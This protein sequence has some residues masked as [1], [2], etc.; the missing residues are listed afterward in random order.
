MVNKIDKHMRMNYGNVLP[1]KKKMWECQ[2]VLKELMLTFITATMA[3]TLKAFDPVNPHH[4]AS[5][6]LSLS[7]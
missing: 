1:Q 4:N 2:F 3:Y 5:F 6:S 7:C